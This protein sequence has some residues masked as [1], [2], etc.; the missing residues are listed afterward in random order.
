MVEYKGSL[1][2]KEFEMQFE[3]ISEEQLDHQ[4]A[5]DSQEL[6]R[7]ASDLALMAKMRSDNRRLFEE[8]AEL[9]NSI[10]HLSKFATHVSWC[11]S[12]NL[13]ISAGGFQPPKI[14]NCG[15]TGPAS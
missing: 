9:K 2:Q 6:N 15:L 4:L 11:Q 10:A 8:N 5:I 7:R 12:L 3:A 14:C 1:E 13:S